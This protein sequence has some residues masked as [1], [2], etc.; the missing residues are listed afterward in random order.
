MEWWEIGGAGG[1]GSVIGAILAFFGFSGRIKSIDR[2]VD[3]VKKETNNRIDNLKENVIFED[4]FDEFKEGLS[5]RLDRMQT[6]QDDG[7][8]G[9][10]GEIKSLSEYVRNNGS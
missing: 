10:A 6:T 5:T 3:N 1:S 4:R 2:K 9:I 8:K 7:F